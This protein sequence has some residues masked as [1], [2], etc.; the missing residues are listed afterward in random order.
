MSTDGSV[1]A[2]STGAEVV[3]Y[4]RA[5]DGSGGA[6]W[7]L[8]DQFDAAL[9]PTP[10]QTTGPDLAMT[11]DGA[12]IAFTADDQVYL[13]T[14][15]D[16]NPVI[17]LLS[18]ANENV[19]AT[20][21]SGAPSISA[22][23]NLV[24]FQSDATDLPPIAA[25]ASA[26]TPAVVL[27]DIADP[28]API[29]RLLASS[30]TSPELA[31]DG[32]ALLYQ[33]DGALR[34]LRSLDDSL[35]EDSRFAST[36]DS[37]L[38][39]SVGADV[40]A[41]VPATGARIA[42]ADSAGIGNRAVAFDAPARTDLTTDVR[43]HT[44][45]QVWVHAVSVDPPPPPTTTT[46]T[47]EAPS[48]PNTTEPTDTTDS[49][50]TGPTTTVPGNFVVPGEGGTANPGVPLPGLGTIDGGAVVNNSGFPSTGGSESGASESGSSSSGGSS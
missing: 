29:A 47:T 33:R 4:T 34:L 39:A 28:A 19:P 2:W 46:T 49:T 10:G 14:N 27:Y 31:P 24:V 45:A 17:S 20:G 43:F 21:V 44:E 1:A 35:G 48:T 22:D 13:W 11:A 30:A 7:T 26:T 16:P 32:R 42:N 9:E 25:D 15:D 41:L 5:V 8:V 37:D 50:T 36:D 18:A 40:A 12:R 23:G 3:R 38:A 6:T